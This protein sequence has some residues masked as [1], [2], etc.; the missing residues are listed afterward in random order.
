MKNL[1]LYRVI[2]G[3]VELNKYIIKSCK[4]I[5]DEE[6]ISEKRLILTLDLLLDVFLSKKL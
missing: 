3:D 4:E 5:L 2:L 1:K 6:T